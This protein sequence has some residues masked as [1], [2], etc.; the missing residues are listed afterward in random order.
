MKRVEISYL[1]DTGGLQQV[2]VFPIDVLRVDKALS[3]VVVVGVEP[4][5]GI[6]GRRVQFHLSRTLLCFRREGDERYQHH[7]GEDDHRSPSRGR[8]VTNICAGSCVI[9]KSTRARSATA[10]GVTPHAQKTG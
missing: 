7:G 8:S 6:R 1:V 10:C 4:I 3:A 2:G 5:H 9:M